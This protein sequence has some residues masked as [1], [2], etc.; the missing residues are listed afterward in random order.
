MS[1]HDISILLVEDQTLMH[2]ELKAILNLEAGLRVVGEAGDGE[3]SVR[4]ALRL[5]PDHPG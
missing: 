2:E 5:R 1:D 4:E 3:A